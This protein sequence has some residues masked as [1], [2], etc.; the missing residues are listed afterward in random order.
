[1]NHDAQLTR[2][3]EEWSMRFAEQSD[4]NGNINNFFSYNEQRLTILRLDPGCAFRC[5]LLPLYVYLACVKLGA[6]ID[7][8]TLA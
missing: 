1:M 4:P 5:S 7:L 2:Y 8:H 6:L 3:H